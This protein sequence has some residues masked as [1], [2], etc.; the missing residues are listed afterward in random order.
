MDKMK[1]DIFDSMMPSTSATEMLT[2]EAPATR[3]RGPRKD[4]IP[5]TIANLLKTMATELRTANNKIPPH[6]AY[7][8]LLPLTS[9][10]VPLIP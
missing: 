5:A 2:T 6:L 10:I 7:D 1:T 3:R 9:N 8:L 4:Y